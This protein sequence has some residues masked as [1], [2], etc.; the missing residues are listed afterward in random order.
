[1]PYFPGTGNAE[2]AARWVVEAAHRFVLAKTFYA[3]RDCTLCRVSIRQCPV[4]AII[5]VD[6][7]RFWNRYRVPRGK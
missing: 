5:E 4:Q 6:D 1:M 7:H 2:H 3:Y